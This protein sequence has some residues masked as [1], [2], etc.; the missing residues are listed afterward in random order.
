[1]SATSAKRKPEPESTEANKH[2]SEEKGQEVALAEETVSVG[3]GPAA[4]PTGRKILKD[5]F[6]P[7]T[8]ATEKDPSKTTLFEVKS[9]VAHL[10]M[11]LPKHLVDY[12]K[13]WKA[14]HGLAELLEVTNRQCFFFFFASPTYAQVY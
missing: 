14:V 5:M 6:N 2:G 9:D 8:D 10:L 1:M 7:R 11:Y 3:V 13:D 12:C 4:A